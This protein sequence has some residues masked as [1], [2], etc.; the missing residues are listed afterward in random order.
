[1]QVWSSGSSVPLAVDAR[2]ALVHA[3]VDA[4]FLELTR[5]LSDAGIRVFGCTSFRGVFVPTGFERGA[6]ALVGGADDPVA[7]SVSRTIDAS[8]ARA[9]AKSAAIDLRTRMTRPDVLLLYATP[10]FEE[11]LLEGIHDAFE[12]SPPPLY[13]GSAADD[14]L[15]GQWRVL[16]GAEAIA[17][18]FV[19]VG[20]TSPRPVHGSFVAGYTPGTRRG[21]VTSASGRT[22]RTIDGRPAAEVYDEWLGGALGPHREGGGVV[23]AD[24]TMHPLGR[25]V[26]RVGAMTRY[27]LTHP[28]RV[29]RDGSLSLFTDVAE[30]DE[31]VLMLGSR[32]ALFDRT[33]QVAM[34]AGRGAQSIRGGIL[35]YCG[36]CVGVTGDATAQVSLR[37]GAR[38]ESAPFL[39]AATFGEQG[40]FTGPTP[41]NRHGNLM[42]DAVLFE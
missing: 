34:R 42:A 20:F 16:A 14:D 38:L 10:G 31:L 36:G 25:A 7:E 30:G 33:D 23:L 40:C 1:M 4:P 11:R 41:T 35:V 29:E 21:R 39:G 5:Q 12:G 18:G 17:S 28:H 9:A 26:D 22:L 19:L 8:G 37:F 32:E 15:S 24:T 27:L 2:W 6:F 3:T 13:G